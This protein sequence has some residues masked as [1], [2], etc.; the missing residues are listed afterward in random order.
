MS[1]NRLFDVMNADKIAEPYLLV[2]INGHLSKRN[3]M[4]LFLNN[5]NGLYLVKKYDSD[6]ISY[7]V[8]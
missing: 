7:V 2:N 4:A 6:S 5:F 3:Y 8:L 1:M